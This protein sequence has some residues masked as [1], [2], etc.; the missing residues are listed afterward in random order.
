MKI[1]SINIAKFKNLKKLVLDVSKHNG[2]SLVI[3]NN[4]SG[5]SNF[6]EALSEIF[7]KQFQNEESVFKYELKYNDFA[8]R[9]ITISDKSKSPDLP[10]RVVAVYSGEE[11][12][13]WKMY[14][15]KSY[16]QFIAEI[17]KGSAIDFPKML[18]LNK[19]YWE[20]ALLC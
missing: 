18:Y 11:D 20:I 17:I 4:A 15:E 19:F 8:N 16:K 12:R 2:L 6:L 7:Y 14:Y 9:A 10:K 1:Q 5:K 3:G 13:L